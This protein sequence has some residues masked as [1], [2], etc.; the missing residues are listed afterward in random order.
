MQMNEEIRINAPR[1]VVYA[2]LNNPDILQKA[3]PGCEAL[4]KTSDSEFSATIVIK[5]GPIKAKFNGAVA[6]SDLNPPESY[7]ISGEG[8]AGPAGHAK[9]GAKIQLV[10]DGDTTILKYQVEAKIGGKLAQLG[11]RLVDS[12]AKKLAGKFFETF[13]GLIAQEAPAGAEAAAPIKD[14]SASISP[15]AWAA[16]A[17]ILLGA[18]IYL[19]T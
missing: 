9:G 1:E 4:D 16:G 2:A 18:V 12:T 8:K 17:L 7:T 11:S 3:I 5:V 19:A 13:E 14:Q 6:L 10:E 15:I